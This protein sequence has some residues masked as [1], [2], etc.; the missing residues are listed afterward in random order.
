MRLTVS[1]PRSWPP[2][3]RRDNYLPLVLL[4]LLVWQQCSMGESR[5]LGLIRVSDDHHVVNDNVV[6]VDSPVVVEDEPNNAVRNDDS[7]SNQKNR[8][9]NA[10]ATTNHLLPPV[11]LLQSSTSAQT[12]AAAT[13]GMAS[14]DSWVATTSTAAPAIMAVTKEEERGGAA[15]AIA[16]EPKS[17]F[18]DVEGSHNNDNHGDFA[19]AGCE[20]VC[21]CTPGTDECSCDCTCE[22]S[23]REQ[24]VARQRALEEQRKLRLERRRV[25]ERQLQDTVNSMPPT[26]GT[27]DQDPPV[28][29]NEEEDCMIFTPTAAP[30]GSGRSLQATTTTGIDSLESSIVRSTGDITDESSTTSAT[31]S[32]FDFVVAGFPKC[33]TTALLKAFALHN[34]TDMAMTEKCAVASP[35]M[36]D[37]VVWR[38][39]DEILQELSRERSIK[40]SFKCPTAIY[41]H[42]T[43]ARL[44]KHSPTAKLV[45]GVRHPIHMLQSFYNYRVTEIY[46]RNL[47]EDVPA[48]A[49]VMGSLDPWKGVSLASPRYELFLMQFGKT[50]ISP[51]DIQGFMGQPGYQLAIRP[52]RF[53]IFLYSTEQL[54]DTDTDRA[55]SFREG[56]QEYLGLQYPIAPFTHENV[57]HQVGEEGYEETINI[58]DRQWKTVRRQLLQQGQYSAEWIRDKFLQSPDVTVINL[59]HFLQT[60][61]TWT[62]DPCDESR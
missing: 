44:E 20:C 30:G 9:D 15:T 61:E 28:T 45:I 39:M 2:L 11:L 27:P 32:G 59:E 33:G 40:R 26:T 10:V 1:T 3:H 41:N 48:F 24:D 47:D 18:A 19:S 55:Q 37:F 60:L 42:K 51:A 46:Q 5:P 29:T 50:D 58:C 14:E 54:E 6:D 25:Y 13:V 35:G 62:S 43:I 38:K 21:D 34:E 57:N 16:T 52:S 56:L 23:T 22:D 4:C 17:F 8:T 7:A 36:P 31:T 49:D 53:Q 12:M